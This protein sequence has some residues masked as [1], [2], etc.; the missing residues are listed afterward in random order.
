MTAMSEPDSGLPA[1]QSNTAAVALELGVSP[2][3]H[4]YLETTPS[5]ADLPEAA[6]ARRIRK[7]FE[8]GAASGL[9]H[10]GAVELGRTLTPSLAFGRELAH[11][12]MAHLCAI[13]DLESQWA[14][15][16]LPAPRHELASLAAAAPPLTG[17]EYLDVERLEAL[18]AQLL[19][20]AR[21]EIARRRWQ[22]QD[23][24][25]AKHPSWNLVGRVCFHLAENKNDERAPFAFLATYAARVSQ[26][27]K[28][29]H[30]PLSRALQNWL[31]A[32]VLVRTEERGVYK[33]TAQTEARIAGYLN[34]SKVSCEKE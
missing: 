33:S 25:K 9:L 5:E 1:S 23:W 27:A 18:W 31:T 17:A 4:V 14:S 26:Q 30:R 10:H 16:A 2:A 13:P 6:V 8:S 24:L 32:G 11:L 29:Q 28:V 20:V 22:L 7:S 34:R 3:G 19:P 21:E 15:A 12:F